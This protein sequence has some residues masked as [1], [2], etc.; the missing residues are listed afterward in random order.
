M[1]V[2]GWGRCRPAPSPATVEVARSRIS[3]HD[4]LCSCHRG[5]AGQ[6]GDD[7]FSVIEYSVGQF[8]QDLLERAIAVP[9]VKQIAG[10]LVPY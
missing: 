5:R 9:A 4:A 1:W 3:P 8:L 6:F 10:E 7:N 2:M